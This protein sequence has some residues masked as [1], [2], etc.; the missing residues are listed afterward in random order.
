VYC[1]FVDFFGYAFGEPSMQSLLSGYSDGT[2]YCYYPMPFD[3]SAKI[4]LIYRK[5]DSLVA[6]ISL[7][8][9]I[10]YSNQKRNID[11]EGKFY[12]A[13]NSNQ[14]AAGT[15]SHVFLNTKGRGHY[16]ASILQSRGLR[17]GMTYFFE[18]DDS[19]SI[20]GAMRMHGTGSEDYFNG[21]WYAFPDRWDAK[22]S[23]P[24]HGS[25]AYSL[26]FCRTGGYRLFLSDKMSFEKSIFSFN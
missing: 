9:E 19:I 21:G 26:P 16:V 14:L 2:N 20:D 23:L 1:P 15:P 22:S 6:A 18:G 3:R 7:K 11:T 12:A 10:Y 25:L 5:A 17:P 8:A 4:E 13:W 24:L